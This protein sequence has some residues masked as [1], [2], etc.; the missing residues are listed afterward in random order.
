MTAEEKLASW[1]KQNKI[2]SCSHCSKPLDRNDVA[3]N[4][5]DSGSGTPMTMV[6]ISCSVCLT[7]AY[8]GYS[9]YPCTD[10]FEELIDNVLIDL[11]PRN[12]LSP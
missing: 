12:K 6:N 2:E 1:L 8:L 9:W 11:G 10:T 7:E 4:D 3:W 5:A